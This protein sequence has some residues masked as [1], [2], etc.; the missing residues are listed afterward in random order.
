MSGDPTLIEASDLR[1]FEQFA[2]ES[3]AFTVNRLRYLWD[4]R[5]SNGIAATGAMG[6]Y[7]GRRM[8]SKPRFNHWLTTQEG[9][10]N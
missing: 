7:S 5:K 8:V 9:R 3:P 1:T 4:N 10:T 2:E 6:K